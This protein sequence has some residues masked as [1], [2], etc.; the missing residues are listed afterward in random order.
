[1]KKIV[2][3]L[4]SCGIIIVIISFLFSSN[5]GSDLMLEK[6]MT[7]EQI[8]KLFAQSASDLE[9][10]AS[11]VMRDALFTL[12]KIL[13][14]PN[15]QRTYVNTI[16]ALDLLTAQYGSVCAVIQATQMVHPEAALRDQAQ[17]LIVELQNFA[18]EHFSSNKKLYTACKAY[19]AGSFEHEKAQLS[20]E[21]IYFIEKTI[22]DFKKAGLELPDK[23]LQDL[24]ALQK[25]LATLEVQFETN[26]NS[27]TRTISVT[28]DELQG[29]PESF[30]AALKRDDQGNY[31]LR[32]DYPTRDQIMKQCIIEKTREKFWFM[33]NNRGYPANNEI[34]QKVIALRDRYAHMLGF[35]SYADLD[36][37]D[38][39]A[40]SL[41]TI[42]AF[43]DNLIERSQKKLEH[44]ISQLKA[45]L[46]EEV[47]LN[48]DGTFKPWDLDF[49]KDRY[50]QKF[51][52]I[53]EIKIS[54]YF[55]ME[56]TV[57]ALLSIYEKFFDIRFKK[58]DLTG[59][60]H[61]EVQGLEVLR[62]DGTLIGYLLLDLHPREFKYTHACQM[63]LSRTITTKN[64]EYYPAVALVIANFPKSTPVTPSLLMRNDVITFFHEFGHAIHALLGSTRVASFSGTSVKMDFV[65]MPSQMLEEW[66][67]DAD[68]IKQVSSHYK[69]QESLDDQTI[70]RLQSIKN[71]DSAD[72]IRRQLVFGKLSLAYFEPGEDKDIIAIKRAISQKLRPYIASIE[73][74]HFESSFGHLMGYGSKYY[75][76]L[77]SKVYALDL[78]ATI[79]KGGLLNPLIGTAYRLQVIGKGGSREPMELL[80]DFLGRDP[81]ADAFFEDIGL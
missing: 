30:I 1:M 13:A 67:W 66:M 72:F 15:D 19:Y 69:T 44:E 39:M 20:E 70:A 36:C 75:G 56:S 31:I 64:G 61:E 58:L 21:E 80:R 12:E 77:W 16:R 33:F 45:N 49:I 78:F 76:Y 79:K 53:D 63:T 2:Y 27:D 43:L 71:Y 34:L 50:K 59:L 55:P 8:K 4:S 52:D 32:P 68:I 41:T 48:I 73:G 14:I 5:K 26:I 25:E 17:T 37:D 11:R 74:E 29:V 6:I 40:H 60:W 51:Y 65:E 24:S 22:N 62:A 3:Y 35:A 7:I 81:R 42:H 28:I 9:A 54:E 10:Q 46:P 18:I 57:S 23:E 47:S 38:T